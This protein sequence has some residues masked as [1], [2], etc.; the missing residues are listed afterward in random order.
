MQ[1]GLKKIQEELKQHARQNPANKGDQYPQQAGRPSSFL[2]S[3]EESL[4]NDGMPNEAVKRLSAIDERAGGAPTKHKPQP[5][6]GGAMVKES[7]ERDIPEMNLQQK[8]QNKIQQQQ[9]ASAQ[10]SGYQMQQLKEQIKE[11]VRQELQEEFMLMVEQVIT[12]TLV[13]DLVRTQV[14]DVIKGIR[15]KSQK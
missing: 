3:L 7:Y 4:N 8:L 12:R 14:V 10:T 11:E 1:E 15:N 6:Q 5:S 9:A 13:N 2:S